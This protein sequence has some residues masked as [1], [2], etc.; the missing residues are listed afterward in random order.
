[1]KSHQPTD[2]ARAAM[3]LWGFEISEFVD[4]DV[5]NVRGWYIYKRGSL[6]WAWSKHVVIM[7]PCSEQDWMEKIIELAQKPSEF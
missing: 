5:N 2:S 3:S 4:H 6:M 7:T 1:M